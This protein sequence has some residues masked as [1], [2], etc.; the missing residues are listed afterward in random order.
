MKVPFTIVD[1]RTSEPVEDVYKNLFDPDREHTWKQ[2]L[3]R[4]RLMLPKNDSLQLFLMHL[5]LRKEFKEDYYIKL[6]ESKVGIGLPNSYTR[7]SA[8][9]KMF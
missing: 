6:G 2:D 1:V 9:L 7:L 5:E 4:L 8:L 3:N